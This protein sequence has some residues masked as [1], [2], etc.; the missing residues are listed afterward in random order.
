LAAFTL[1]GVS[2]AASLLRAI[3][4]LRDMNDAARLGGAPALYGYGYAFRNG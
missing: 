2:A 3:D 4:M 1:Q